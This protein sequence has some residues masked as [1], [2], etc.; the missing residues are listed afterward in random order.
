MK[1][2]SFFMD[3]L[4]SLQLTINQAMDQLV[5]CGTLKSLAK[6][7]AP[8]LGKLPVTFIV[9]GPFSSLVGRSRIKEPCRKLQGMFCLTAAL[10]NDRKVKYHFI[11]HSLTP[12]HD[13]VDFPF[14]VNKQKGRKVLS[15]S[16]FTRNCRPSWPD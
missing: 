4:S 16:A 11:V 8:F 10:R 3:I 6:A 1:R 2:I 9:A 15:Y 13:A 12:Q 5:L 14:W 7:S